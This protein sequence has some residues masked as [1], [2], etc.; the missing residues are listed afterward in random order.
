MADMV[1]GSSALESMSRNWSS[2][3]VV[4]S[5]HDALEHTERQRDELAKMLRC[6]SSLGGLYPMCATTLPCLCYTDN[7]VAGPA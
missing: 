6:V 1:E 4:N 3:L 5:L 2:A 7:F